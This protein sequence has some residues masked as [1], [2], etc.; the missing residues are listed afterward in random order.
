MLLRA[1]ATFDPSNSE[2]RT[3]VGTHITNSRRRTPAVPRSLRRLAFA[4]LAAL[5]G[6]LPAGAQTQKAVQAW[7]QRYNGPGNGDD[8]IQSIAV[9]TNGNVYVAGY[10]KGISSDL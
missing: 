3:A 1:M 10:S 5:V 6:L 7:A 2:N 4:L 9:D 8:A